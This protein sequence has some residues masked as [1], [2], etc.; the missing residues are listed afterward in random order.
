MSVFCKA[1]L[2]K[3]KECTA[4]QAAKY[5]EAFVTEN[6][7]C[8]AATAESLGQVLACLRQSEGLPRTPSQL[9]ILKGAVGTAKS[10]KRKH[11]DAGAPQSLEV[12]GTM[13]GKKKK[14]KKHKEKEGGQ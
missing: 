6:P 9:G 12:Q 7:S 11:R 13:E 8:S 1:R 14:K 10:K 2:L 5:V 3:S 4:E